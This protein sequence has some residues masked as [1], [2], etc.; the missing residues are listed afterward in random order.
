MVN[1]DGEVISKVEP[2][3]DEKLFSIGDF[4]FTLGGA[5]ISSGAIVG[6]ALAVFAVCSYISWKKRKALAE[7]AVAV[8]A[9]FRRGS[10]KLRASLR[11]SFG[12][13]E[14][15]IEQDGSQ[16]IFGTTS[17]KNITNDK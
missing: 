11:K 2:W 12:K 6:I 3:Y 14:V 1:W 10:A 7:G 8:R 16:E 9:S 15:G 4:D 13:G 17:P 5:A